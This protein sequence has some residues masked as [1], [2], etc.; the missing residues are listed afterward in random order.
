MK[1]FYTGIQERTKFL[2]NCYLYKI[3]SNLNLNVHDTL[4]RI[5]RNI[6]KGKHEKNGRLLFDAIRHLCKES[7]HIYS[8]K[9]Y[10]MYMYDF[11]EVY[12]DN[13]NVYIEFGKTLYNK[14]DPNSIIETLRSNDNALSIFTDGSKSIKSNSAGSASVCLELNKIV[15]NSLEESASIFT[16]EINCSAA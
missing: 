2:A 3:L 10:N 4:S 9:H 13:I 1:H 5:K 16:T 7:D 12:K 11:D 14:K 6:H 15:T 8:N